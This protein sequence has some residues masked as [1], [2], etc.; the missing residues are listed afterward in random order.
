MEHCLVDFVVYFSL[1]YTLA[2][3]IRKYTYIVNV[4]TV[5]LVVGVSGKVAIC[6]LTIFWKNM[7]LIE[8]TCW[9]ATKA[10]MLQISELHKSLLAI[11]KF[12]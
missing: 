5:N 9:C 6:H 11:I 12:S 3:N 1:V 8:C 10:P 2:K 4:D 7:N